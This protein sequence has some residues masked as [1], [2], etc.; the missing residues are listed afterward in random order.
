[1]E[2]AV[3]NTSVLSARPWQGAQFPAYHFP[4]SVS[5][6]TADGQNGQQQG[7]LTSN[8]GRNFGA[9][10]SYYGSKEKCILFFKRCIY[11]L[12]KQRETYRE[13]ESQRQR[14]LH[15]HGAGWEE[16]QLG[17]KPALRYGM[18]LSLSASQPTVPGC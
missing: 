17:P 15:W 4:V 7:S 12:E 16:D 2:A 5:I 3:G 6:N 8:T 9:G 11:C 10:I 14:E 1:M 18:L 13:R